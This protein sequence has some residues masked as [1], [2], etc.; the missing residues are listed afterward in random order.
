MT[1]TPGTT[2]PYRVDT[3]FTKF[4]ADDKNVQCDPQSSP[5]KFRRKEKAECRK[6]KA[7]S[8]K[9]NAESRKQKAE[10]RKQKAESRKQKAENNIEAT[11]RRHQGNIT[12]TVWGMSLENLSI[13]SGTCIQGTPR[14]SWSSGIL[15]MKRFA[16]ESPQRS[17][18][19][20]R[21]SIPT[22]FMVLVW[23]RR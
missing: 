2:P 6:Q 22:R 17:R 9:Q 1:R 4:F 19:T 23:S 8:R 12:S 15:K 7:E 16:S 18:N 20:Q 3:L 11:L 13:V 5:D 14:K 10:S 21:S